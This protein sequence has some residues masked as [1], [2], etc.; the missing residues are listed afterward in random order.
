MPS[1]NKLKD[2]FEEILSGAKQG[3]SLGNL[4]LAHLANRFAASNYMR[5]AKE[6]AP[7]V[8]NGK[9]LDW[10]CGY[11]QLSLLMKVMGLDVESFEVEKRPNIEKLSPFCDLNITYGSVDEPFPY[12]ADVFDAVVSCGTLEHVSNQIESLKEIHRALKP[13][14]KLF[15]YM[16]PNR[17]S[18][19]EKMMDLLGRSCH[20]VKFTHRS[21]REMLEAS[22][23]KLVGISRANA[24]P[25]NLTGLPRRVASLYGNLSPVLIPLDRAISRVPLLNH[26]CG[27]LEVVAVAKTG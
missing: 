2:A 13:E 1:C 12:N 25:H 3:V 8:G 16:L 5:F 18:Y 21:T 24:L 14:G 11:G 17:W 4:D 23:F 20:P 22:G 10:G 27:V 26:A 15:I 9:I 6:I 19:T 7:K